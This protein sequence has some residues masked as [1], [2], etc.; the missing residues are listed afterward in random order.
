MKTALKNP[1]LSAS[2]LKKTGLEEF[3]RLTAS[4]PGGLTT[5]EAIKRSRLFGYNQIAKAKKV[6]P[7]L[8][9]L[10]YFKN[11]LLI[12]LIFAA[13][14]SGLT[15]QMH[16]LTIIL[17]IIFLS[18]GLN[19]YQ[20]RK[21]TGVSDKLTRRL[22][23]AADVR[24]DG[25]KISLNVK[26]LV[27]GDLVFLAAGD[28]VPAD[29]KIIS[30]NDFFVNESALTGESLPVEKYGPENDVVFS[31]TNVVSGFSQFLVTAIGAQ[32]E[33]GRLAE[34]LRRP[35]EANAFE[36]GIRG[37]GL[38]IVRVIA[39]IV[40]V[41]FFLNA[42]NH[43]GILNSFL[44]ALAVA[45]GITP[46]L[47][48]MI[49][50]VNL[51]KGALKMSRGGVL[52]K[53]LNA[54]PTFGSMDVLCTDKTGTLTENRITL[55]KHV[56]LFGRDSLSVFSQAY[57]NGYFE[58]GIKSILD[59]AILDYRPMDLR[60]YEK[61]EELPYSFSRKRS[62]IIYKTA[63]RLTMV[64]KGAPEEIFKISSFYQ[65]NGKNEVLTKAVLKKARAVYDDLSRQ[66]LRLL[67]I[68]A[69]NIGREKKR[70]EVGEERDLALLG[71]MAF[72]DPPKAGVKETLVF[73]KAHG[74]D[75]KIL[76]G[77]CPLVTEKI[78][79]DLD[80]EIEGIVTGDDLDLN[81]LSDEEIY[82][83]TK[84][85]TI[86]ARL[87]PSQK[88]KI[89]AELKRHG[90][91][92]GYLGDGIN[93]AP[94]LKSADVGISVDNAVDV[95]KDTADIILLEKG[96]KELMAGVLE[97]RKSFGNTMKYLL[98]GLSSNFGNMF[99]LIGASLFLPFFPMT[100]GQ[101]LLNNF[102][103]DGSQLS[104]PADNVDEDYLRKP[105]HPHAKNPF[106]PVA[107]E[108]LSGFHDLGRGFSRFPF[109]PGPGRR[110]FRFS[111][112]ARPGAS[113]YLL[114]GPYL[115][116]HCGTGQADFLQE[117][118]GAQAGLKKS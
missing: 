46:E 36:K 26:Y 89:I 4:S 109:D 63:G 61:V 24:R 68:A 78:C 110:L 2:A 93:D 74:V 71:F 94:S 115:S 96:L 111:G 30:A 98:M 28:I 20:E 95:A 62:S 55:I 114:D 48:P 79:R 92:V 82:L 9:F 88:E 97:G 22:A 43:K 18:I 45:V 32:T 25:R 14:I 40:A 106:P 100:A 31:G 116:L 112:R 38:L 23:I 73:M 44:F 15:G 8:Q 56:D 72:Y 7:I 99:S 59:Q 85:A 90:L 67:A 54:I 86:C 77:D 65:E 16:S 5:K 66:G 76:T 1:A 10:N 102:L 34:K 103:Y 21:A 84:T 108:P 118:E 83:K 51:A 50:S 41:I 107:A 81:L 64:T 49:I 29:G 60:A 27:P 47:L 42:L 13:L 58:T 113:G 17:L 75:I 35:A 11:P 52:V 37:F 117:D 57:L 105:K 69:K 12:V 53:K 70:Y 104:I 6:P 19:F 80:L 87:S 91:T 39:F 3:F 101:I 33:L